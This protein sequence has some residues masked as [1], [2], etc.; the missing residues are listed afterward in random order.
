MW[1][2][3]KIILLFHF[4]M[5]IFLAEPLIEPNDNCVMFMYGFINKTN[6]LLLKIQKEREK[7]G[8]EFADKEVFVTSAYK[9][10]LEE[11]KL[12]E[13]KE[14]REEYLESIGDV[15]KQSDLG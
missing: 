2:T 12:E 9:K 5:S 10:K 11:M 4:M 1:P 13:E 8:D 6:Y 15:T 7:E 14:K 3:S